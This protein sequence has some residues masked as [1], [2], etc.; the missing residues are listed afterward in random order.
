MHSFPGARSPADAPYISSMNLASLLPLT[1]SGSGKWYRAGLPALL[2]ML[3]GCSI[4]PPA[5]E[6]PT[7]YFVLS[8]P[9]QAPHGSHGSPGWAIGLA[10]IDVPS[11]LRNNKAMIVRRSE[12]EIGY[13]EYARWAEPL[14][15]GLHAM[16]RTGL[17]SSGDV[18]TVLTPPYAVGAVRDYELH[19]RLIRC[20]GSV[21]SEGRH[22]ALFAASYQLVP[23][24]SGER[25]ALAGIYRSDQET[26][27]GSDY[28]QLASLLSAA[29]VGL[30]EEI[31]AKMR[32]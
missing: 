8:S 15:A 30:G 2:L 20:E 14:E 7:R 19:L 6:D 25:P 21:N 18:Q 31:A 9:V 23:T 12:H 4:V 29:A 5:K 32:Q 24:K 13:N 10:A 28:G 16:V 26:W 27:N 22:T 11:Y 17:L 3:S 1:F